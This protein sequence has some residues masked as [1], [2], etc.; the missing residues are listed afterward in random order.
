[1]A[2]CR[3]GATDGR[4]LSA[5]MGRREHNRDQGE[6]VMLAAV[7]QQMIGLRL[8]GADVGST[9]QRKGRC[10]RRITKVKASGRQRGTSQ[11]HLIFCI[12]SSLSTAAA[13]PTRTGQRG[14]VMESTAIVCLPW[15]LKCTHA[16][17]VDE[18]E[19]EGKKRAQ[20]TWMARL[21]L[22]RHRW[23]IHPQFSSHRHEKWGPAWREPY[24]DNSCRRPRTTALRRRNVPRQHLHLRH[25]PT[26]PVRSCTRIT[27]GEQAATDKTAR[28][29]GKLWRTRNPKRSSAVLSSFLFFS[30]P[31][32]DRMDAAQWCQVNGLAKPMQL[33]PSASSSTTA[34]TWSN[35]CSTAR[36][37]VVTERR[38]RPQREQALNCP[39]CNSTNTKFCYYNNYS[40]T[41]PRY[42]CKTCRRYWT[43]GG[44]LRNVPVGGGSRKNK[45]SFLA[46]A[47]SS[48]ATEASAIVSNPKKLP[49]EHVS[50]PFSLSTSRK[51]HEGQDL[52]LAFPHPGLPEYNDFPNLESSTANNSSSTSSRS[53]PCNAV[54][55]FSAM[56][57]LSSGMT[58]REI[59]TFV[60]VPL[61]EYP[62]GF[63]LQEL[64]APALNFP[65]EGI[66]GGVGGGEAER[67]GSSGGYGALLGMQES[68]HGR[69]VFPFED[70]KPVVADTSTTPELENS[71]GEGVAPPGFWNGMIG[72]GGSW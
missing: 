20:R 19:A 6:E 11:E 28:T 10:Y 55:A 70:V 22:L 13:D 60:P 48:T 67:G 35:T 37:Q 26:S 23:F 43:E 41:Q 24:A 30:Q 17:R 8:L 3:A 61:P 54:G 45:K 7:Q 71:R 49:T 69:L 53:I 68:A 51:F 1:M 46:T 5:L 34:T 25:G 27:R 16:D 65:M 63:G 29:N 44:S 56:E 15:E 12:L 36:S 50:P 52:N 38:A 9:G 4:I 57:L 66:G 64:R 14:V 33:V 31:H 32:P 2:V 21:A 18:A 59:R 72:G 47:T 42:F 40:L 39:R 58:A 62:T